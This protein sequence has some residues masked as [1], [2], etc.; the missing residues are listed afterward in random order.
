[1]KKTV[2]ILTMAGAMLLAGTVQ[3]ADVIYPAY[4]VPVAPVADGFDWDGFYAGVGVSGSLWGGGARS[5]GGSL[6]VGGNATFDNFLV[7]IEGSAHYGYS[8]A[9]NDWGYVLGL[10]GRAGYLV[11]PEVLV[12]LSGGAAYLDPAPSDWYATAGAGVEFAVTDQMSV[13]VQYRYLWASTSSANSIG[14][15]ALWHF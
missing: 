4:E 1:M 7:G 12:Y 6:S 13:D 11:A 14:V 2:S 15:S 10:E 8:N 5:V 9:T 3:A